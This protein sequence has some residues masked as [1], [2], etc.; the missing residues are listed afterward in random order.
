MGGNILGTDG[1]SDDILKLRSE[2]LTDITADRVNQSNS[3]NSEQ[4]GGIDGDGGKVIAARG[5]E[6]LFSPFNIFRYSEFASGASSTVA[7]QYDIGRHRNQYIT[8]DMLKEATSTV[9]L[10]AKSVIQNPSAVNII[11]WSNKQA[12]QASSHTGPLY[13]YPYQLNDFL[14]CK[15]YGKIPNNRLL[16]LRRYP[17]PVEDNLGIASSKLPLVPISQAVTWWGEGTGNKLDSVLGMTWGLKWKE[18]EGIVDDVQGNEVTVE[19]LL[20]AAGLTNPT[21]RQAMILAFSQDGNPF[22]FSG[23][24]KTLQ[25]FT[26]SSWERGAYWNRVLGPVNVINKTRRRE[27]GFDFIHNITL[28]FEYN[29]RSYGSINP[30]IAML[31]LLSNFMSLTYNRANFWGGGY[32]YF[33][34]TGALL[35][36][37]DSTKLEEGDYIGGLAEITKSM[38]GYVQGQAEAIKKAVTSISDKLVGKSEQEMQ[39]IL[40]T[41]L[42]GSSVAQN[43]LAS[44]MGKLHQ[45]PLVLRSL[46][47]GRA[48]GE[49]HLMVGNPMDPLAVIGNLCLEKTEVSFSN[50][51][52]ADDFPTSIKFS[53]TLV[54]G[55]PR[56]KQD[57]ESMFNH[58]GGDLS[59]TALAP[60]S[61]TMDSNGE[62]NNIR[63][64]SAY[65]G[66]TSNDNTNAATALTT[67]LQKSMSE[68]KNNASGLNYLDSDGNVNSAA[69]EALSGYFKAGVANKYGAGFGQSPILVDY[70]KQLKTKD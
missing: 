57:I 62:Y 64:A 35:P 29:L 34:Q 25:D 11:D 59:F 24:D 23:Y 58:G 13:P 40:A 16:T 28:D 27:R 38:S 36:G 42:Q 52:G 43:L 21:V 19:Q 6:S 4:V 37:F 44:R 18:D 15:W 39:A 55:R 14:W 31:D 70:F 47:D 8:S 5:S 69:A 48:V 53:L 50:E 1:I 32:R 41:E 33:Q 65:G 46:L 12:L 7:G 56:A 66:R 54:S 30:K 51:L 60:P 61:S 63:I 26:K 3:L 22:A 67:S 49:W 17:I 20:D 45:A 10:E 9:G 68:L 2:S